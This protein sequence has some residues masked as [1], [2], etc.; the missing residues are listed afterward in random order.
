M[1]DSK[2]ML[3]ERMRL[4]AWNADRVYKVERTCGDSCYIYV[5]DIYSPD[6]VTD[7]AKT[8]IRRFIHLTSYECFLS[9]H[10]YKTLCVLMNRTEETFTWDILCNIY[11]FINDMIDGNVLIYSTG[12][13][14]RPIA[15]VC[16][17]IMHIED[18]P[19]K[20]VYEDIIQIREIDLDLIYQILLEGG[21]FVPEEDKDEGK[22]CPFHEKEIAGILNSP[23]HRE[24]M[25][26][27]KMNPVDQLVFNPSDSGESVPNASPSESTKI[28]SDVS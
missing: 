28:S 9:E 27:P 5:G 6:N 14:S 10:D 21:K 19:F 15:V 8:D 22:C 12:G 11:R 1:F 17:L 4:R 3:K 25:T 7:I 20:T 18:K 13:L 24:L 23:R 16:A 2:T 26:S